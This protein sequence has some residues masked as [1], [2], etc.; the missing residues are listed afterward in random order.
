MSDISFL[1]ATQ[2]KAQLDSKTIGCLELCDQYIDRIEDR[3]K[4]T[5]A[6]VVRDFDRAREAAKEADNTPSDQ[7]G[8]AHGLP[9]TI[10]EAFNIAGL[11]TTWGLPAFKDMPVVEDAA[12]VRR[13]KEAGA[14]FLGKTNVPVNLGDFQSYNPIYGTTNNPW[15]FDRSPGGSSG[16]SAV[17]MAAGYSAL[18][19]GSDI[20]GSI[21]NPAHYCGVYGHK[22]TWGIV[23]PQGHALP[24]V[25]AAPDIAVC[26]PLAR[27]AEDLA[28]AIGVITGP[29]KL[30]ASGW[31]LNL[32]APHKKSLKEFKVA[33]WS[34]DKMSPVDEA[35][36]SRVLEVAKLLEKQGATVS[37]TARPDIEIGIAH[38]TFM[39]LM[40][41]IMGAGADP[42]TY[43]ASQSYAAALDATDLSDMTVM[44][45]AMVM[46]HRDWLRTNN[47]REKMRYAWDRFFQEWDIILCP[48]MAT[49][50]FLHDQ[51]NMST[52]T[53]KVN[54]ELQPYF[55][56]IFWS[57][58][59]VAS[60]LPSTVFPTGPAADGL[61][62][63]LQ[64]ISGAY[65]DFTSIEF[66][67]L[68]E[69]E[70]GGFKIP[71]IYQ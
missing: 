17:A 30:N 52:R 66:A 13:Y 69:L 48:Q 2:L 28:L 51:S 46:S 23:P 43:K 60:Y 44:T 54:E 61:P 56:Q 68:L 64:A 21:R 15:D 22:P 70:I 24:G 40:H 16:G 14:V 1:S 71:S 34:N 4:E 19:T 65:Q 45:R 25:L 27:S 49:T 32:P 37:Y 41:S 39:G 8:A 20:G 47:H 26:G 50:A 59:A 67:R 63:G 42:K 62:L 9:L 18:E 58:L 12:V 53:L 38:R 11:P 3:D 5:N 57:G 29:E 55:Q 10:K 36:E 33:V 35:V 31:Q 7:K 6:V